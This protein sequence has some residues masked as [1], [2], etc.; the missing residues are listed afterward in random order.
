MRHLTKSSWKVDVCEMSKGNFDI[1]ITDFIGF[2]TKIW[3][4]QMVFY[5]MAIL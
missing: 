2:F 5:A 4:K 1:S 3:C